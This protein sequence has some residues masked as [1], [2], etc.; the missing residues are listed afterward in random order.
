MAFGTLTVLY[1]GV[2]EEV[3]ELTRPVYT[4]GS[5]DDN[6]LVLGGDTVAPHHARI[7]CD[8]TSC[9]VLDL[10]SASGTWVGPI[11]IF[12]EEPEPLRDATV[13]R[14]GQVELIYGVPAPDAPPLEP[15]KPTKRRWERRERSERAPR[16]WPR[17]ILLWTEASM[18]VVLAL[19]VGGWYLYPPFA[20][21]LG[22]AIGRYWSSSPTA[23]PLVL[24]TEDPA[25]QY[26]VATA[27]ELSLAVRARPDLTAPVVGRLANGTAVRVVEGPVAGGDF[28][29]LHIESNGVSGWSVQEGLR[30]R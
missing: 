19:L 6:D 17:R 9:H 24:P 2:R 28:N 15:V 8:D 10:G 5:A 1:P 14:V 18:L 25:R 22:Q 23:A 4:V 12:P 26:V 13:V 21:A 3:V 29:W 11:R 16:R 27:P 7:V 20:P 30:P